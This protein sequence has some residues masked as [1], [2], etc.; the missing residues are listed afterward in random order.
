VYNYFLDRRNRLH[1]ENKER[2]SYHKN[3][4]V[5]TLLKKE[6]AWIGD[7]NNQP[8]QQELKNLDTA[9]NRFFKGQARFP[10]FHSKKRDK[11]NFQ[12]PQFVTVEDNRIKFPKF[13]KGIKVRL[14][15]KI[16]GEIK[17]ATVSRNRVG[18]YFVCICVERIIKKLKKV[19]KE[20]SIDFGVKNLA[21]CSDGQVFENIKP[22]RSLLERRL[23]HL[24]LNA[25]RKPLLFSESRGL[26]LAF[27]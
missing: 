13:R 3:C 27:R 7:A 4:A 10:K 6:L 12:V 24:H 19:K 25:S 18:Q 26:L 20:V 15:R 22:Y 14:H 8:L 11:Q 2:S 23:K 17:F 9:F 1:R 5:L 16:E 21:T